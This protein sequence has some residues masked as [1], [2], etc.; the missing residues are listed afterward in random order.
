QRRL[1]PVTVRA[2]VNHW[3]LAIQS[4]GHP[5]VSGAPAFFIA[6]PGL[7][8]IARDQQTRWRRSRVSA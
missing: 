6:H 1:T 3:L 8:M 7:H 2:K 4:K 5:Q